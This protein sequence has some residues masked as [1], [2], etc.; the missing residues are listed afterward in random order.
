MSLETLRIDRAHDRHRRSHRIARDL[1]GQAPVAEG[2]RFL[3]AGAFQSIDQWR[4]TLRRS[5][6][7]VDATAQRS[8]EIDGRYFATGAR[9]APRIGILGNCQAPELARRLALTTPCTVIGTEVMHYLPQ[10]R[11]AFLDDF[12]S[13]D[14]IIQQP[15]HSDVFAGI[16]PAETEADFPGRVITLQAVNFSGLQ[17]DIVALGSMNARLTSPAGAH[18]RIGVRAYLAGL[19]LEDTLAMFQEDVFEAEGFFDRWA[20]AEAELHRRDEACTLKVA[21]EVTT[22]CRR[23]PAMLTENHPGAEVYDVLSL[24]LADMLELK[25][26]PCDANMHPTMQA[27]MP[28]WPVYD[29]IAEHHGLSYRTSQMFALEDRALT[30]R[31]VISRLFEVYTEMGLDAL[32]AAAARQDLRAFEI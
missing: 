17:P 2:H 8:S 16:R 23:M 7:F 12:R 30:R 5:E 31:E 15:F 24:R 19:G 3:E 21:D 18:S 13:C 29:A 1:A 26:T 4:L 22:L 11:D 9:G 28:I 25:Y 14:F 27:R 10:H 6:A 32:A 20:V